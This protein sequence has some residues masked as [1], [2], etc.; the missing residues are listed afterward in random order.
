MELKDFKKFGKDSLAEI[1]IS[2]M[3][4]ASLIHIAY[5]TADEPAQAQFVVV[6]SV[7]A[8]KSIARK[9]LDTNNYGVVIMRTPTS[10][11]SPVI[12][13]R[14]LDRPHKWGWEM[15]PLTPGDEPVKL[16]RMGI[17]MAMTIERGRAQ[18]PLKLLTL[19]VHTKI[20]L[21]TDEGLVIAVLPG[22]SSIG[23]MSVRP[24]ATRA[25]FIEGLLHPLNRIVIGSTLRL[26]GGRE[27]TVLEYRL[28]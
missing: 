20:E 10:D 18:V 4:N 1:D 19:P 2:R 12:I 21:T 5:A 8:V 28:L 24:S 13:T 26:K 6:N 9:Q 17:I 3:R 15:A 27:A 22:P 14:W 11:P 16:Q 23:R 25:V 7:K